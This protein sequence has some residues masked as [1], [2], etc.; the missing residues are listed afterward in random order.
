MRVKERQRLGGFGL[1]RGGA[2]LAKECDPHGS[3]S[4]HG[5]GFLIFLLLL[6]IP[7]HAILASR[8][9]VDGCRNAVDGHLRVASLA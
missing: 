4:E 6:R 1:P 8:A 5:R 7:G 2:V 9:Y 3:P